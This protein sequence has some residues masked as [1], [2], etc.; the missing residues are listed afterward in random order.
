MT[1]RTARLSPS[2]AQSELAAALA[3]LRAELDVTEAFPADVEAEA[4]EA[5][6]EPLGELPDLTDVE[7]FTIDPAGSTDLDQAMHL[8]ATA[9][10]FTV[11]Y[12]IADVPFFVAP[13][14]A[15]DIEAR[16]RGQTLY[17]ADGR[18][19]LHPPVISEDAGSLLPHRTRRA[20]V[21]RF[22]L[23]ADGALR[24]TTLTRALIRSRQQWTYDEAQRALENGGAPE[25]LAPL[26]DI[27]RALV[28][29]EAA[30]GGASLNAPDQEVVL[31]DGGYDLERRM[32]LPVEDWNA[33]LSL[34]TGMAAARIMLD[35]GIGILR[36][37]P[38]A[39]PEAV[40]AFRR[41]T[42]LLGLPWAKSLEYGEYL[43]SLDRGDP[44]ALAVLQDAASLF[45]GAGYEAFDGAA[46]EQRM[47][48]AL[49]APYAHVTAP[50][51]RL[52]DRWGLVICEAISRGADVPAWARASLGS[53]P[54]AMASSSGLAGR[55]ESGTIDRIEAALLA[56]RIGDEFDAVVLAQST[57]HTRIQLTD[58][59]VE[60]SV[61]GVFG[62]PGESV[63]VRLLASAIAT[64]TVSFEPV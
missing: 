33:Q 51:R 58:P 21:W 15:L 64:G 61:D 24:E 45:R 36:T 53:L 27:G 29:Q 46:P 3:N 56:G 23:D 11:R 48:A 57:A 4:R 28:A 31:T 35:A 63:R 47:Q 54:R 10:G 13:G 40:A 32:P 59:A 2:A 42:E 60:A 1:R 18:V 6:A 62:A 37:M 5:A 43:R 38:P 52:V 12:A 49:A 9:A 30:R 22:A 14:G 25:G 17:A 34:L 41:Q 19:P 26:P 7:F 16:R 20:F 55:L 44:R 39:P 8:T 50:L